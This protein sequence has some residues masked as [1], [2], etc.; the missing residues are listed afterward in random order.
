MVY[1][2]IVYVGV[3]AKQFDLAGVQSLDRAADGQ[4]NEFLFHAQRK[5]RPHYSGLASR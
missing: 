4:K 5:S 2:S 3:R 1:G